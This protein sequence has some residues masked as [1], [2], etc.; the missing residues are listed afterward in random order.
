M[1]F[2]PSVTIDASVLAI[3]PADCVEEEAFEY[4]ETLLDWKSLLK[5]SWIAIYMSE[6]VCNVLLRCDESFPRREQLQKLFRA[7]GINQYDVNTVHKIASR[8]LQITPSFERFY[9][10]SDVLIQLEKLELNP[11]IPLRFK[12]YGL[13]Q[14]LARC[15]TMTAILRKYC[16]SPNDEHFIIVKNAPNRRIRIRVP[17][18][19][20]EHSRDDVPDIVNSPQNFEGEVR[21]CDSFHGLLSDIDSAN[22]LINSSNNDETTLAIRIA[23][24]QD[25]IVLGEGPDWS[26]YVEFRIGSEFRR[27]YQIIC[28]D[29]DGS[30]PKK[31]LRSIVETVKGRNL[32][33]VHALRTG[34]GGGNPMRRRNADKAQRRDID[35]EF[36]LHYWDLPDGNI[37]LASVVYHNDFSIPH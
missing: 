33:A 16:L 25:S 37:E 3:P 36:H 34:V 27:S 9:K 20:F 35:K 8:L 21:V 12:F 22:I 18:H 4:V 11:D 32:T 5:E 29:R 19:M 14:E 15:L 24:F 30:V 7:H 17:L 1:L 2:F 31:I 13:Q 6:E 10:V 26:E 28:S 23:L